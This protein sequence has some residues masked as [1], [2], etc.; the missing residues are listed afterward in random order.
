M[1]MR[2]AAVLTLM[3]T[4]SATARSQDVVRLGNLKFAHYG[5]ISYMKEIAG[6]YNLKIEERIFAKGADI[7]PAMAA[8]LIDIAASGG[9]GAVSAR[10]NGVKLV[11]VAGFADGGARILVRPDLKL[12]SLADAKGMK[13]ATVRGGIQDCSC[14]PNSTSMA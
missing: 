12:N 3:F 1:W 5:T 4:F 9:D 13:V 2:L 14:L 10:G 6:K 8:D 7:Y 11:V